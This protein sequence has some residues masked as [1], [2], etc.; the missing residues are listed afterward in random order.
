MTVRVITP[1]SVEPVTLEEARLWCRIDTDDTSQ[2]AVLSLLITAMRE[3]AENRT[4]RAFV[5][6]TLELTLPA[7]PA[8]GVIELPYP[9]LVSVDWIKYYD[10]NGDLITVD[11]ADYEVDTYGEPGRVQPA[12]LQTWDGTRN[13]FNAVI[14]RYQAGY[15]PTASP[16]DYRENMPANLKLFMQARIST[17]F[18]NREQ[19]VNAAQVQIPRD[20]GAGL[21]DGLV[22]GARL[23]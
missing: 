11:P 13:V 22:T 12:Y 9:P 17:L 23:F 10:Y 1:P 14:V 8:C 6:R 3:Y 4:G 7:F 19:I 5:Q 18:E 20:F 2:D 16:S 21:L 15:A